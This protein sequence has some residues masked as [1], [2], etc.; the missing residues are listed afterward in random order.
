MIYNSV[1]ACS[2]CLISS[3]VG[4][5]GFNTLANKRQSKHYLH[6]HHNLSSNAKS[7]FVFLAF[8]KLASNMSSFRGEAFS[9]EKD[10]ERKREF[11]EIMAEAKEKRER[12]KEEEESLEE[13]P[14]NV[15][16]SAGMVGA[17]GFYKNFISPLLPP[18]CRFLPTCSQYGVQAIEEF[19]PEKGLILIAWRL[20][21]CSPFGGRGYDPP[22]WPPV[23]Y[24]YG[25]Y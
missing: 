20:M 25:S 17:I 4:A 7:G 10:D 13:K 18:A 12:L 19:G 14:S 16:V 15:V 6:Q 9:I 5:A 2:S 23:A 3:T 11:D 1:Q 22:K 24:N 8:Q 21:R